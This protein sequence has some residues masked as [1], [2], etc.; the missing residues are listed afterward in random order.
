M[1]WPNCDTHKK[2]GHH[3]PMAHLLGEGLGRG[4]AVVADGLALFGG[5]HGFKG[6]KAL[7]KVADP[8]HMPWRDALVRHLRDAPLRDA[9]MQSQG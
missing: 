1:E 2:N 4:G 9:K 5:N 7:R 6:D 8:A 3:S